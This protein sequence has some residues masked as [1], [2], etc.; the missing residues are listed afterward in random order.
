METFTINGRTVRAKEAD[1]NFIC[2]LGEN[3]I[4]MDDISKKPLNAIRQYVA[5]C[6]GVSAEVAGNELNAHIINGGNFE[7]IINVFREQMESSGFFRALNNQS[8][9]KEA[10]ATQTKN[11]KKNAKEASE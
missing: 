7:E 3:S 6:M 1:F 5:F 2:D 4:E 10:T 8:G 11:T 9:S